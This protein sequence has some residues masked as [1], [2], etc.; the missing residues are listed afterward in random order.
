MAGCSC[1]GSPPGST[2]PAA[3]SGACAVTATSPPSSAPSIVRPWT[4][5]RRSRRRPLPEPPLRRVQQ[6]AGHPQT[7]PNPE[8]D[9]KRRNRLDLLLKNRRSLV[10]IMVPL[11]V[12]LQSLALC[13]GALKVLE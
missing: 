7:H 9:L 8:H 12:A 6:R 4:P 3:V 1:A 11:H 13:F 2:K 5:E 10:G